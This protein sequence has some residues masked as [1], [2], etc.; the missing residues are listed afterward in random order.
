MLCLRILFLQDNTSKKDFLN[1]TPKPLT[2]IRAIFFLYWMKKEFFRVP[3][4]AEKESKDIFESSLDTVVLAID[5]LK[6]SQTLRLQAND[7]PKSYS[8]AYGSRHA[9]RNGFFLPLNQPKFVRDAHTKT[10]SSLVRDAFDSLKENRVRYKNAIGYSFEPV[11][12]RHDDP[13]KKFVPFVSLAKAVLLYAYAE[14]FAAISI[15][16]VYDDYPY[17]SQTGAIVHTSVPSEE[18]KQERYKI[19]FCRIPVSNNLKVALSLRSDFPDGKPPEYKRFDDSMSRLGSRFIQHEIAGYFKVISG[20]AKQGNFNPFNHNPFAVL[21][22]DAIAFFAKMRNQSLVFDSE[23]RSK[24]KVRDLRLA[25]ESLILGRYIGIKG[26]AA[27]RQKG[28]PL[29]K[30]YSSFRHIQ[31]NE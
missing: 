17:V 29:I 3:S 14:R 8:G 26:A 5:S 9:Y 27:L 4:I 10:I 31:K 2:F 1:T 7:F 20:Y 24:K 6:P 25:E 21:S 16:N 22:E 11:G 23:L 28:D 15:D 13:R 18:E 12:W 19:K 30:D